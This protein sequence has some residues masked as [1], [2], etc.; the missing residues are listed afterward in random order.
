MDVL[1]RN[2]RLDRRRVTLYTPPSSLDP[3]FRYVFIDIDAGIRGGNRRNGSR[4]IR[5]RLRLHTRDV[6]VVVI[7][8][9]AVR[10]NLLLSIL[11]I[12]HTHRPSGRID[13]TKIRFGSVRFGSRVHPKLKR[14]F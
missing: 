14:S 12:T 11:V 2:Q 6:V 8:T 9:T 7:D 13:E 5:I 4:S 1:Q 10:V 3:G